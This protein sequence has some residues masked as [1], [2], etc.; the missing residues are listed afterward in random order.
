MFFKTHLGGKCTVNWVELETPS[1]LTL[2]SLSSSSPSSVSTQLEVDWQE[3]SLLSVRGS[4]PPSGHLA[5]LN[6]RLDLTDSKVSELR[7]AAIF[8]VRME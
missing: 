2:E 3:Y 6:T 7:S 4:N 5:R 8:S 1:Q